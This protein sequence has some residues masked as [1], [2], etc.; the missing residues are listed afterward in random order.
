MFQGREVSFSGN[1]KIMFVV[2]MCGQTNT[3]QGLL[4]IMSMPDSYPWFYLF[5]SF[6]LCCPQVVSTMLL[7]I[8]PNCRSYRI[9][10]QYVAACFLGEESKQCSDNLPAVLCMLWELIEALKDKQVLVRLDLAQPIRKQKP[11]LEQHWHK[12][13]LSALFRR[14]S[15]S[16]ESVQQ[17]LVQFSVP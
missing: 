13:E 14:N 5:V 2:P 10:V 8:T 6:Q 9:I 3:S 4:E 7:V 11:H 12:A 16:A 17:L 1:G 15:D